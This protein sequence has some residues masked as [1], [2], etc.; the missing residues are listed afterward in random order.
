MRSLIQDVWY[1]LRVLRK[2][3]GFTA[4]AVL[5]MGLGVGVNTSVF[6]LADVL[7]YRPLLVPGLDRLVIVQATKKGGDSSRNVSVPDLLDWGAQSQTVEHLA[8][9]HMAIRNL[10]GGGG[11]P[12]VLA[13]ALVTPPFFD[14]LGA[15]PELGRA[16]LPEGGRKGTRSRRSFESCILGVAL[17]SE[18][19][20][21][22]THYQTGGRGL[23][24]GGSH[25]EGLRVPSGRTRAGPCRLQ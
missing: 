22:E 25:A 17:W 16:F 9:A 14:A 8:G 3:P 2:S 18:S 1:G 15:K 5:A 24:S 12:M 7:V 21:S 20:Y 4:I 11:E 19:G 10:S 6:S 23:P 13:A